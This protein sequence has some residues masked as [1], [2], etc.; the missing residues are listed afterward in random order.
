MLQRLIGLTVGLTLATSSALA[1]DGS[2]WYADFDEA[3][4]AA[5]AEGKDLFV[6]FTGSDWCG[7]CIKLHEEVFDHES[8]QKGVAGDYVLVALD[9]PSGDEAKAK[10][11]NPERNQELAE[12]YGIRGYPT[13]MLMTAEGE[14]FAQT[15]YQ[16]GGPE[17]YLEHM[18]EL[19]STGR[20][21]LVKSKEVMAAF[22]DAADEAAKWDAW[23]GAMDLLE[24][25]DEGSPFVK[26]LVPAAEWGFETDAENAKGARARSAVAL[27]EAG[28]AGADHIAYIEQ[29]DPKNAQGYL[30]LVVVAKF[31][32]VRDDTTARA[33]LEYLAKVNEAGF[34]DKER[35]FELNFMAVRWCMGPLS[36][37]ELGKKHAQVCK[38]LGS[39]D[40]R[41]M[42][43][44]NEILEG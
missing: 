2:K 37:E 10:V 13:I 39:D 16:A 25:L 6:D 26:T 34:Q 20:V 4:K 1:A 18:A 36:D 31:G 9:F 43:M 33:A 15:G 14:V 17:K 3:Q 41:A 8:W 19:R 44:I 40:E 29:L 27:L 7:W 11:P 24:G 28:A 30:E 21:A 32:E 42:K 38:T 23:D 35:A 22:E 5:K 12:L